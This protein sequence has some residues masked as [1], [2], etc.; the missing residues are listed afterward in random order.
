MGADAFYVCYGLRWDVDATNER[1]IALLEERLDPRQLAAKKHFLET[2]WGVT[3]NEGRRFLL[4]G[5]LVGSFGW[6]GA[7]SARLQDGELVRI[8]AETK[9]KLEAAGL[10]DEPAW[11]YQF[12][13]D[14]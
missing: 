10:K 9:R 6:E 8:V 2:R 1:E 4:V 14:Y 11:H 7:Q 13:P 5:K 3:A 12:E